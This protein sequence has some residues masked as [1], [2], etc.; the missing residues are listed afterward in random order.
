MAAQGGKVPYVYIAVP[1]F[2][3]LLS[4]IGHCINISQYLFDPKL[5]SGWQRDLL[6]ECVESNPGPSWEEVKVAL[7]KKLGE[8]GSEKFK[9]K[10][11]ALEDALNETYH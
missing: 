11:T 1:H 2:R 7:K 10:I 8:K 5:P 9:D 4:L 6:R 3:Y